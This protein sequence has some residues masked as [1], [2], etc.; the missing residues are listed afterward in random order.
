MKNKIKQ[1]IDTRFYIQT[2]PDLKD[3]LKPRISINKQLFLSLS[4]CDSGKWS[5][6]L[7]E[8]SKSIT[9]LLTSETKIDADGKGFAKWKKSW[10]RATVLKKSGN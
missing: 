1:T 2:L 9:T 7:W 3:S 4:M 6:V 5:V 10:L 8:K